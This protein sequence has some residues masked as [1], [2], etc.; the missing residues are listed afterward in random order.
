M[1]KKSK[2]IIS[3][4]MLSYREDDKLQWFST[5]DRLQQNV[6]DV[7]TYNDTFI[8]LHTLF[9][10]LVSDLSWMYI[11]NIDTF[12]DMLKQKIKLFKSS[13][14]ISTSDYE[15][16]M[17]IEEKLGFTRYC[18]AN[19]NYR[20]RCRRKVTKEQDYCSIHKKRLKRISKEISIYTKLYPDISDIISKYTI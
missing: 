20:D 12:I 18:K 5:I 1:S 10:F 17:L 13:E 15:Y 16:L 9:D 2:P 3:W 7:E 8:A 14:R 11:S 6:Q 4:G 19:T